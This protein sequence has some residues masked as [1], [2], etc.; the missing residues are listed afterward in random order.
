[1]I[2]IKRDFLSYGN[3]VSVWIEDQIKADPLGRINQYTNSRR[4]VGAQYTVP[5]ID[6]FKDLYDKIR[7]YSGA[8]GKKSK[9]ITLYVI[10]ERLV[11]CVD[12]PPIGC[13]HRQ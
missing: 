13:W 9:Y 1:M 11:T 5:E 2:E 3:D 7:V 12:P 8:L 4:E 10:G 6:I